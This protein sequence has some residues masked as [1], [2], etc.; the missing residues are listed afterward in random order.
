MREQTAKSNHFLSFG[1]LLGIQAH[2]MYHE[3]NPLFCSELLT[4]THEVVHIDVR[5]LDGLEERN[6]PTILGGI[7]GAVKFKGYDAPYAIARKQFRI[8]TDR[9][10]VYRHMVQTQIRKGR[11]IDVRSVIED[12]V[13]LVNDLECA[14]IVNLALH[15]LGI[16]PVHIVITD[17]TLDLFDTLGNDLL[18]GGCTIL[19]QKVFQ[20]ISRNG[21]VSLH[22][23]SKV[24]ADNLTR[25]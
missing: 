24:L 5:D 15:N 9:L 10:L 17:N 3:V 14:H 23:K 7:L 4:L 19:S 18:I 20:H 6:T 22:Q 1:E 25:E 2:R 12:H 16:G 21:Q 11:L 13:Y 8:L